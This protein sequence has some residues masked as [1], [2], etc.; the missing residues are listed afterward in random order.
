MEQ[1][2]GCIGC[3][4]CRSNT[5][6]SGQR[7]IYT[8]EERK[9]DAELSLPVSNLN[10]VI[11]DEYHI[12]PS[13]NKLE[14]YT[15]SYSASNFNVTINNYGVI[16]AVKAGDTEVSVIYSNGVVG[17][18]KTLNVN[19]SFGDYVPVVKLSTQSSLALEAGDTYSLNPM[20][21]FRNISYN[22]AKFTFE[23]LDESICT[24]SDNGVV[25]ALKNG[26]TKILI[27]AT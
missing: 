19:V 16:K 24:V 14:G 8:T 22:D 12:N 10:L 6:E 18:T 26:N 1:I 21:E 23:S 25:T 13:Y 7:V 17:Y 2:L 27:N 20:V 3:N 15:L 9:K 5:T 4:G 11:G